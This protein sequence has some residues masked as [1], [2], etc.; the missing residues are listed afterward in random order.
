MIEVV[1]KAR[2]GGCKSGHFDL[3]VSRIERRI[4]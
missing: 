1:D 3:Q 4:R 2:G